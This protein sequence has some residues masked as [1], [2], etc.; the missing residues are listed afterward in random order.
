MF[1][2]NKVKCVRLQMIVHARN[3]HIGGFVF[4]GDHVNATVQPLFGARPIEDVVVAGSPLIAVSIVDQNVAATGPLIP[5]SIPVVQGADALLLG[6]QS[7]ANLLT[8]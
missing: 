6:R 7:A 4:V 1:I 3:G 5:N 8:T 2:G